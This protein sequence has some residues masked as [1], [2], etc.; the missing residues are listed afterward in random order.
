MNDIINEDNL[1]RDIVR[2]LMYYGNIPEKRAKELA[3]VNRAFVENEMYERQD[4]IIQEIVHLEKH[5]RQGYLK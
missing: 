2:G 5:K 3:W 1:E 4:E